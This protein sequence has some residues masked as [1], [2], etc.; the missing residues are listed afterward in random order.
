MCVWVVEILLE[1][2]FHIPHILH[3]PSS[4]L[5]QHAGS[6]AKH[7]TVQMDVVH[8]SEAAPVP[9]SVMSVAPVPSNAIP[10]TH[11]RTDPPG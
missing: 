2:Q 1:G 10:V 4:N 3:A 5:I 7:L 9:S 8:R 6:Q 11:P